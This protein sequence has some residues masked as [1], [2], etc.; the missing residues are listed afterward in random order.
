MNKTTVRHWFQALLYI[1]L[2]CAGRTSSSAPS[3][4]S[5]RTKTYADHI[6]AVRRWYQVLFYIA[7]CA[8]LMISPSRVSAQNFDFTKLEQNTKDFIVIVDMKIQF[9]FG[10]NTSEEQAR[11]LGTIVTED[12]LVVF[13]GVVFGGG[14]PLSPF[15]ELMV[16][17]TPI[18]IEVTTLGGEKFNGEYVGVD[19]FTKIGFVRILADEK[20]RFTPVKFKSSKRFE[21]G[22]W[23]TLYTLL[24]EFVTPP[25]AADVGMVS[26]VVESPEFFPLTVGFN[27][28]QLTSVLFDQNLEPVGVLGALLDPSQTGGDLSMLESMGQSAYPLLGV[29]SGERLEKL[30]ADPPQKGEV[31]R[32][33]LGIT[34]QALTQDMARFW[35]LD[36]SGGIIVNDVVANSPAAKVGLAV[37]DIIT[38]V[39][40]YPIEIDKDEKLPVF[41]RMIAELG[42]GASAELTVLRRSENVVDTLSLP[43][44]LEEAPL[45][46]ADAPSYEIKSLEFKVRNLVFAD[47]MFFNLDPETFEGVVVSELKQG[48]LAFIGGLQPG[49]IIQRIGSQTVASV[50]DVKS[51][52]ETV[53]LDKPSEVIFFV[54]RDQKTLF[55]NVK[56]DWK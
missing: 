5:R 46:A 24:P 43:A 49:D 18:N 26:T 14:G 37:G 27:S 4:P 44:T 11:Y 25:L 7:L 19:R 50:D 29:I 35:G 47:F 33:W 40:G 56:T 3:F 38:A 16:K 28:L 51:V 13:N 30:I 1:A 42:S 36:L 54:W 32:G 23:L 21:K 10:I 41:Q 17:T 55:V 22:E 2:R 8:M 6:T 39:N 34:I 53:E 12:G 15:A 48:G 31:D 52:M 45:A 20:K 9:S